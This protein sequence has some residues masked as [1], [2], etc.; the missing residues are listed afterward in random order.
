MST[1]EAYDDPENGN[2]DIVDIIVIIFIVNDLLSL[3]NFSCYSNYFSDRIFDL[4]MLA[5]FDWF[6]YAKKMCLGIYMITGLTLPSL[7]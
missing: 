2:F 3:C 7:H 4:F 1:L 6:A 5:R